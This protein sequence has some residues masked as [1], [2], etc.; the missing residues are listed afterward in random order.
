MR[1]PFRLGLRGELLWLV[2]GVMLDILRGRREDESHAWEQTRGPLA[3]GVALGSAVAALAAAG[4][5]WPPRGRA[6]RPSISTSA[7]ATR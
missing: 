2:A 6:R 4:Q 7:R 1:L 3:I 5:D